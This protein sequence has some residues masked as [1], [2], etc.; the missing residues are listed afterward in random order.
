MKATTIG[1]TGIR[2]RTPLKNSAILTNSYKA[3]YGQGAAVI[4]A[5]TKSGTNQFHGS[6]WEFLR[7]N[8]LNARNFLAGL[9]RTSISSTSLAAHWGTNHQGQDVLFRQLRR[10]SGTL[11]KL[12]FHFHGADGG[13]AEWGFLPASQD[14]S[15]IRSPGLRFRATEFRLTG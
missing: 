7:N 2:L 11:G 14:H 4:N 10:F 5:I 6:A 1:R 15:L 12:T 13:G 8:K 9:L 3:E